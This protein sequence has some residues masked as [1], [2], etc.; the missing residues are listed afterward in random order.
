ML[1]MTVTS[2]LAY[3]FLNSEKDGGETALNLI[4]CFGLMTVAGKV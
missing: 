3:F 4:R 1:D 2:V